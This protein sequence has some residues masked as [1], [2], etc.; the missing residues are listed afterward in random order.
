MRDYLRYVNFH[1]PK[2]CKVFAEFHNELKHHLPKGAEDIKGFL[3]NVKME[4]CRDKTIP[5]E[6]RFDILCCCS[7]EVAH[8]EALKFT[9]T[10]K[11]DKVGL[12]DAKVIANGET[13][14][15]FKKRH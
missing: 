12:S 7:S 14:K 11:A 6:K 5:P 2:Y 9:I 1:E 4:T 10:G 3:P 15:D 13:W 8:T